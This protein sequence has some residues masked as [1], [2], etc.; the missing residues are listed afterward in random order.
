MQSSVYLMGQTYYGR[1]L[2]RQLV[3]GVL[4]ETIWTVSRIAEER[5][6]P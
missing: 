1:V 6:L 4:T 2:E 5:A 3:R